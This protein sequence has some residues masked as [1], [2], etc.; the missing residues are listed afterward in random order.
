MI[1]YQ[2]MCKNLL[3]LV[4]T[5][6]EEVWKPVVE[7][8]KEEDPLFESEGWEIQ[9]PHDVWYDEELLT[10]YDFDSVDL[11]KGICIECLYAMNKDSWGWSNTETIFI[12]W[13]WINGDKTAKEMRQEAIE[14]LTGKMNGRRKSKRESDRRMFERLKEEYG[15]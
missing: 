4:N 15:W 12:P 10:F 3:N 5:A 8:M 1:D 14:F 9:L 11:D 6:I 7:L 2:Q 13:S